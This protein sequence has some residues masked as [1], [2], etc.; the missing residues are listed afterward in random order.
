MRKWP[1]SLLTSSCR[2]QQLR[3][4]PAAKAEREVGVRVRSG[5]QR[6]SPGTAWG[7]SWLKGRTEKTLDQQPTPSCLIETSACSPAE[8]GAHETQRRAGVPLRGHD[9][10]ALAPTGG[11]GICKVQGRRAEAESSGKRRRRVMA[12]SVPKQDQASERDRESTLG[13]PGW[14]PRKGDTT[15]V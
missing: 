2:L 12:S 6:E 4:R 10:A 13:L 11:A 14:G 5:E 3:H 8:S 15:S 1:G 9:S 7:P